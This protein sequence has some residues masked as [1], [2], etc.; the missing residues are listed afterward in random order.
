[1]T[2]ETTTQIQALDAAATTEVGALA[3]I[4]LKPEQY[5][6]EVYQPFKN[7]LASAIDSVRNIDYDITTTKGME[8]AKAA[9]RLIAD[10]RIDAD[11]ERKARK[12]P[13][14]TI[15]KML[16]SHYDAVEARILPLEDLFDGDIK[17]EEQRKEE[18]KKEKERV[19]AARVQAIADRISAI[20][21]M[22]TVT[23]RMKAVDIAAVILGLE[24]IKID[25]SFAEF[26]PNARKAWDEA[27]DALEA[28]HKVA[29]DAEAEAESKRL[30]AEEET[31]KAAKERAELAAQRAEQERVANELAAERK[32]LADAAAA[33]EAAAAEQRR[34]AEANLRAEAEAHTR[35]LTRQADERA[36]EHAAAMKA[37]EEQ[38][39]ALEAQQQAERD[40]QAAAQK[41]LDDAARLESDHAEGLL[42][43][44]AFDVEANT[45]IPT[46][47]HS[48]E[49]PQFAA[50]E[51]IS[52]MVDAL[53]PAHDTEPTDEE[54]I[55]LYVEH[56]GGTP[57]QAIE[58]LARFAASVMA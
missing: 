58:R 29:Y 9:R 53:D 31:R 12:A 48:I 43:N 47:Q 25:D 19:E 40:K 18:V 30:A 46:M 56:F 34:Q 38:R 16:E 7:R 22:A 51:E 54:I 35:E 17:A 24:E 5:V 14:T 49:R 28:A 23:A 27:K 13:I 42:M 1:M 39:A 57:E 3:L 45:P 15:G 33:Q 55:A 11:K 8:T 2:A 52:A 10:I 44:E 20:T 32:R 21:K 6:A 4:T 50:S 41:A 37:L 26:I 36:R